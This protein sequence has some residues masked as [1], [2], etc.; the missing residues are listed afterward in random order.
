MLRLNVWLNAF[1]PYPA[2]AQ[3]CGPTVTTLL[4]TGYSTAS[5]P[6]MLGHEMRCH[7]NQHIKPG[8]AHGRH[9]IGGLLT[10]R[11]G[12]RSLMPCRAMEKYMID[13]LSAAES[14]FKE[15]QLRMGDPDVAVRG[16]MPGR[17]WPW[18]G[19]SLPCASA[20]P[21]VSTPLLS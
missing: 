14:M 3:C 4:Y 1:A 19:G 8:G 6:V 9:P 16:A 17:T 10:R 15:M 11:M 20:S 12:P 21:S 2:A 13:K 5:A 7:I 18:P